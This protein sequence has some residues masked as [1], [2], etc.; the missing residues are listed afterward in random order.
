MHRLAFDIFVDRIVGYIGSYFVKLSGKAQALV[1]AG[2]I[3]ENS[4]ILRKAV[5]EKCNCL[6]FTLDEKSNEK[7]PGD[8]TVVDISPKN[9]ERRVLI[10]QTDE[11]VS[12]LGYILVVSML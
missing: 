11:M 7:G 3:G 2:G 1:F 9:Q 5:T 12:P 4:P 8:D 6:G 10:C